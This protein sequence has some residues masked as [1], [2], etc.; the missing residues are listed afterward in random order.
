MSMAQLAWF[1]KELE[2][3]GSLESIDSI[4]A[5]FR[6]W[7]TDHNNM[8]LPNKYRLGPDWGIARMALEGLEL[9]RWVAHYSCAVS[10][11]SFVI[12][13]QM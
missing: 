13:A 5:H 2:I 3:C 8:L 10:N 11:C 7:P 9:R 1:N 6:M 4:L 12:M